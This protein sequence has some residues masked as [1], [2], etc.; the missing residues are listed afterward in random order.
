M[1]PLISGNPVCS[2]EGDFINP[3]DF[4]ET[5]SPCQVGW[6]WSILK[7]FDAFPGF[8]GQT[9]N[10]ALEAP[11]FTT[12]ALEFGCDVDTQDGLLI[13]VVCPGN[14]A[15]FQPIRGGDSQ[16]ETVF[17]VADVVFVP[18]S[19]ISFEYQV[20]QQG[21]GDYLAV[22]I[23]N[24]PIWIARGSDLEVGQ[25]FSSGLIP[26]GNV[27]GRHRLII[28]IMSAGGPETASFAV[29]NFEIMA[30][31]FDYFAEAWPA[32]SNMQDLVGKI[33]ED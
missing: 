23:D 6:S 14:K 30:E 25:T 24:N 20:A 22:L 2:D 13:R 28:A 3:D 31:S 27:V 17:A 5:L 11:V 9:P 1:S 15:A 26:V 16:E 4:H 18:E 10:T 19:F 12:S 21:D 8:N 33:N 29:S 7:D 32:V